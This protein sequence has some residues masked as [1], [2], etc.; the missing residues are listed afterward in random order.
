MLR[1]GILWPADGEETRTVWSLPATLPAGLAAP[2]TAQAHPTREGPDRTARVPSLELSRSH[3]LAASRAALS[4]ASQSIATRGPGTSNPRRV[5]SGQA[6]GTL[7]FLQEKGNET[8]DRGK[9]SEN[10]PSRERREPGESR[11][12][13]SPPPGRRPLSAL[14]APT[15]A[16]GAR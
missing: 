14:G 15:P 9:L 8:R 16:K 7:A 3:K 5:R 11:A 1:E 4:R 13:R 10:R 6:L 12:V 2:S